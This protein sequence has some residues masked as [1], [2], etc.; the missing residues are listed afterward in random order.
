MQVPERASASEAPKRD[1]P[2][3]LL[4][5]SERASR[6]GLRAALESGGLIVAESTDE[7]AC[8]DAF[9]RL[10]PDLVIVDSSPDASAAQ[11][12]YN[13]LR[14]RANHRRTPVIAL[15]RASDA[16]SIRHAYDSGASDFFCLPLEPALVPL[17]V[18]F[19]LRN[20]GGPAGLPR[21]TT[22][23][24]EGISAL[25]DLDRLLADLGVGMARAKASGRHTA[26]L[27]LDLNRF[28]A[29]TAS[30]S[31]STCE[32]LL[33]EVARRLRV[34]I[35]DD[36]VLGVL[37]LGR[38]DISIARLRGDEFCLLIRD[39]KSVSD[40][41][42]VAQRIL[43]LMA[44]P[45][46]VED[47]DTFL[48]VS[49]GIASYPS[50][51]LSAEELLKAA[52]KAAYC[53]RQ[54]GSDRL[55]FYRPGMDGY[56]IERRSLEASLRRALE[57]NELLLHYQPRV[58]IKTGKIVGVEALVRWDHPELGRVP[59]LNF[60]SLAEE[61]GL[62]VPIGEWILHAACE[63]NKRWQ[64]QGIPPVRMAVNISPVQF[65][66][67]DLYESVMRILRATELDP[68]W[69][70]FELTE[71]LLMQDAE[72]AVSLLQRFKALGLHLSIDDFGT[73]YSSLSYLK[74]FPI[75]A[76]KIDQSF[77][78]EMAT[79]TDD[80]AL[81][82]AIILMGR[83][84]KLRV[85]AEG[86]ET[87]SQLGLLRILQCDEIQGYLISRP[88]AADEMAALLTGAIPAAFAA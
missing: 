23:V 38:E 45:F 8:L 77:V 48:S 82:T 85:V 58:E 88:V 5:V 13:L 49:I 57:R 65:R 2:L 63:Q 59:P 44:E 74:R 66:Q 67:R 32:R 28:K 3:V 33:L 6:L 52:E 30:Y 37:G 12:N 75:D 10:D 43:G 53:A 25:A 16:D 36:D 54:E 51:D 86:V 79:S 15:L 7:K 87:R 50:D 1:A 20:A 39:V 21:P 24:E 40:V 27:C 70:E 47:H 62:I 34:G 14:R 41:G 83:S 35:R 55:L 56:A 60:I 69:L 76:L 9:D 22:G 72:S 61:T 80:A 73:G 4:G 81:V 42:R 17:R 29:V 46:R 64:M 78:R 71:G 68:H 26:V 19:V 18:R 84:L 11:S 31:H